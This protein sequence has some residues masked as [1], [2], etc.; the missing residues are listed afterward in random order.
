MARKRMSRSQ[1]Y[2]RDSI[3]RPAETNEVR[4]DRKKQRE[5]ELKRKTSCDV[6]APIPSQ[7]RKAKTTRRRFIYLAIIGIIIVAVGIQAVNLHSLVQEREGLR[8]IQQELIKDKA[9]Y[10]EELTN[11]N[12]TEYVEQK[13]REQLKLI[14]PGEILYIFPKVQEDTEGEED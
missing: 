2:V 12:S 6:E 7:R 4:E 13:A 11:V 8:R 1:E 3:N 14:M 5:H 9:K 10:E